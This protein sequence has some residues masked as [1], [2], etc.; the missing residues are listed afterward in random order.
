MSQIL[1]IQYPVS[2]SQLGRD[3]PNRFAFFLKQNLQFVTR[4]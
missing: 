3:G 4:T 1:Y 2:D